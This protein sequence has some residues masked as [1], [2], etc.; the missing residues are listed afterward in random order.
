LHFAAAIFGQFLASVPT[1]PGIKAP[2]VVGVIIMRMSLV[3]VTHELIETLLLGN[4]LCVFVAQPPFANETGI[5]TGGFEDFGEGH[6]AWLKRQAGIA[7]DTSVPGMQ[8]GHQSAT[9]R[10]ADGAAGIATCEADALG[11]QLIYVR[12]FDFRL[13]IAAE[14]A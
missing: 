6:I 9:R 8:A 3:E 14:I 7:A 11:G 5:V 2:E 12:G 13:A 1:G 4:P 10:C